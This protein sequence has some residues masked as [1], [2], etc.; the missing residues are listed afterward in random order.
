MIWMLVTMAASAATSEILD[1]DGTAN[2]LQAVAWG[3][4][5]GALWISSE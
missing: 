4:L 5:G 3:L 1:L 2:V